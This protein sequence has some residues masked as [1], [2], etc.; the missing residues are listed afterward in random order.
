MN[1][2]LQAKNLIAEYIL[3][4]RVA[5]HFRLPAERVLADQLGYSRAT[6]GKALS[7]LE[8]E[9]VIIRKKGSGT[10]IT[11]NGKERTMTIALIMRTAYHYTDAYFQQIIEKVSK[12]A[13]DSNIYIQIFDNLPELF[14]KDPEDNPLLTAI[15]NKVIDGV[16][17]ASRMP[18]AIISQISSIC[19]TVS[20]NNIFGG[21]E[22]PCV[23]CDYFHLGFLAGQY[24]LKKGHR[25]VAYITDAISH[26]ETPFEF[27]G[28]KLALEM[29]GVSINK[30]DILDTKRNSDIVSKRVLKFFKDSSYTACFERHSF[31]ALKVI[32]VL[33]NNG[34]R[35]PE[36]ISIICGG[37]Y[38]NG[39]QA[40][41]KL[42]II[43]NQ[44]E[45][46]FKSGLDI[47]YNIIKKHS[48][49]K[50]GIKLLTPKIIENN[51]VID[52]NPKKGN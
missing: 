32:S 36:D 33:Q 30:T 37:N 51:S 26:P 16:L 15:N 12:H 2:I 52:I 49:N 46:M 11:D 19:P 43:D 8:G 23:S 48:K 10:F 18:L 28:F 4:Q 3:R 35:V 25:K 9:G 34:I 17:V 7:I 13:E 20:V 1:K 42:T 22:I 50:G 27:S 39:K 5:K 40:D 31:Y 38:K 6:V 14:K 47:L 41:V 44:L 21:G 24:L 29:G 45:G